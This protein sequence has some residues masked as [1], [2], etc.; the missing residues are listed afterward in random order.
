LFHF[1]F[2]KICATVSKIGSTEIKTGSTSFCIVPFC[3][4][5]TCQ[6]ES[7]SYQKKSCADFLEKRFNRILARFNRIFGP[8]QPDLQPVQSNFGSVQPN[9]QPV[10]SPAESASEPKTP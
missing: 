5:V 9:L 2:L 10:Q 8:A 4:C 6:F 3:H 1:S 7:Q